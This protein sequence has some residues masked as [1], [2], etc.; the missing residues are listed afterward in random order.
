[1]EA[2][3][4]LAHSGLVWQQLLPRFRNWSQGKGCRRIPAARTQPL[5]AAQ[6]DLLRRLGEIGVLSEFEEQDD[7]RVSYTIGTDEDFNFLNGTWLEVFVWDQI[8]RQHIRDGQPVFDKCAF[9]LEIPSDAARKEIDV[10]CL[11]QGQIIIASCKTEVKPFDTEYLDELY[12]VGNLIG[13]EFVTRVFVTNILP[14]PET[15]APARKEYERF[16]AQARDRK[17]VVVTGERLSEVGQIFARQ[18]VDPEFRHI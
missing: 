4:V 12:A 6:R 9:S 3:T 5:D 17:I 14:P 18:T 7:E 10:A 2:A 15:D 13:G 1:V 11:H 16:K 8:Q